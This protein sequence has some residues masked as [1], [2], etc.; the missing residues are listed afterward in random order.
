MAKVKR[1]VVKTWTDATI[2]SLPTAKDTFEFPTTC[3]VFPRP[4]IVRKKSG[5]KA[6]V[7]NSF[8]ASTGVATAII[9]S[10]N[11]LEKLDCQD[12]DGVEYKTASF[13]QV[14]WARKVALLAAIFSCIVVGGSVVIGVAAF[15]PG[16]DVA[17]TVTWVAGAITI[18]VA[19][20]TAGISLIGAYKD[21]S[22]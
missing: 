12:K 10:Q 9:T 19:V 14:I 11:I 22:G 20:L 1:P 18:L 7:A 6:V 5:G 16:T 15:Y 17:E 3:A 21:P 4:A 13:W 8:R 2:A